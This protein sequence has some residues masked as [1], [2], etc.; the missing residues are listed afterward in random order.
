MGEKPGGVTAA[1]Q[2]LQC[3]RC[4]GLLDR[5]LHLDEHT[6]TAQFC[7]ELRSVL[8]SKHQKVFTNSTELMC[9]ERF[10]ETKRYPPPPQYSTRV[11]TAVVGGGGVQLHHRGERLPAADLRGPLLSACGQAH[12][13]CAKRAISRE[14]LDFMEV[15]EGGAIKFLG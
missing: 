8:G 3:V 12:L 1:Q 14:Q 15:Q 5:S 2:E 10:Q 6:T 11:F 9:A 7:H 4:V 13:R